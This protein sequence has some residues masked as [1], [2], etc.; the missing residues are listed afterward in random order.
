M[1]TATLILTENEIEQ[2]KLFQKNIVLFT[3][4]EKQ[5]VFDMQFGKC[6]LNIAFGKLQNIV[7]EEVVFRLDKENN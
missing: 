7:K 2:F 5:K 6:I 4:M 3:I 1:K